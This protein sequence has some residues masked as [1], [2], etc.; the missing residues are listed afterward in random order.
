M[1][2][3]W[4]FFFF[5]A[6][7][8]QAIKPKIDKR[9]CIRLKNRGQCDGSNQQSAQTTYKMKENIF[10][11]FQSWIWI[12]FW[13]MQKNWNKVA[14]AAAKEEETNKQKESIRWGNDLN[15]GFLKEKIQVTSWCIK[16]TTAQHHYQGNLNSQYYLTP[17]RMVVTKITK[18]SI[19]VMMQ[20]KEKSHTLLLGMQISTMMVKN[21]M[22]N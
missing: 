16:T 4:G 1:Q 15:R 14:V 19:L 8:W 5:V 10:I 2:F 20:I 7:K 3:I 21:N 6:P 18:K 22:N 11:H 17:V 9:Y 12:D 13:N